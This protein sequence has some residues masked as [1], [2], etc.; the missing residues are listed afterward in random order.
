MTGTTI[1]ATA[2]ML[3]GGIGYSYGSATPPL[4]QTNLAAYPYSAGTTTYGP[5]GGLAVPAPNVYK[6][7]TKYTGRRIIVDTNKCNDCHGW[8]GVNPTFHVGQRNDA[9]TC[10]FCHNPGRTSQG[11][12]INAST[13]VHAIHSAAKRTVPFKWDSVPAAGDEPETGFFDITYPGRGMLKNCEMCHVSGGYDFSGSMYTGTTNSMVINN[14]LLS[15]T[16]T[17]TGLASSATTSASF[18]PYITLDV[19]YGAAGAG[20]NLVNSPI[21][22]ACFSCHDTDT[23]RSH[24]ELNGGS[25]YATRTAALATTET[26]LVCHGPAANTAYGDF[27]PAIKSVHR[28]W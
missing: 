17:G 24:M 14:M 15:T 28:W 11:W 8:L 12:A 22:A 6:V 3:T 18:S 10:S 25:I 19:D 5:V 7:A 1:P 4:V 9:P 20:T 23:A 27:V 21:A 16:A 13:F 2:I 26:C